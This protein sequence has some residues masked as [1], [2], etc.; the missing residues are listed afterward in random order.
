MVSEHERFDEMAAGHALDA[1][2]PDDRAEFERHH[3]DAF[4][5][6]ITQVVARYGG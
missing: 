2:S 4:V 6:R 3:R 1:L 5:E